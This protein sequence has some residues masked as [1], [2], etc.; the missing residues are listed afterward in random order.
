MTTEQ[1][2]GDST[3]SVESRAVAA[4][5]GEPAP[6]E[7]PE[8]EVTAEPEQEAA[9]ETQEV[10]APQAP[11]TF[12]LEV[13]GEKYVLPK[14]LEKGFLHERDY[15]QKSQNL[16]LQQKQI[17]HIQQQA[18]VA[19]FRAEFE[20]EVA[21]EMSQL[22]AYDAVLSQ[23]VN[24]SEMTADQKLDRM[25]QEGQ[26]TKEREAIAR[27][28]Y[29]KQQQWADKTDAALKD[30]NNKSEEIVRQRVPNWNAD[31]WKAISEHAKQEG[32]SDVELNSINDPRHKLTLWKAQQF[33]ALKAKATKTVVDAKTVKTGPTNPMPQHVK[34]KLNFNKQIAKTAPGSMDRQRVV[35]ARAGSLFAK[36]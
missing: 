36:R 1:P 34:E 9:S 7:A 26:W 30:L 11:E 5:F 29:Q 25:A 10:E 31:T 21:Q 20:K 18:R 13:D 23:K 24:W 3:V 28:I 15:T 4:L 14:K 8:Q 35:E 16:S 22:Q 12:E 17:E 2:T 6:Q 33:D 32:Y 27:S 19:N